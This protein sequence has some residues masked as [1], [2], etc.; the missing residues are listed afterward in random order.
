MARILL[1]LIF[2]A[3]MVSSGK[4]QDPHFSQ[5]FA[6]PLTLNPAF[7]GKIDGTVRAAVNYRNQWPSINKAFQTSTAS[8]DFGIL[9]NRISFTDIWGVGIAGFSDQS[10]N[11]AVK[12]NYASAS[13]AY[14]KG[15]DED[16][17]HQVGVGFQVTYANMIINTS[18]LKFED[19]LTSSGFTGVTGEVFNNST[20]KGNYMDLNAGLLYSGST[21]DKNNFYGGISMYHINRPK[22]AFTGANYLLQPR[23]T[24][25][26]GGYFPV[27]ESSYV[28]VSGLY[29]TQAGAN[30]T[31]VGGAFQHSIGT[32]TME[33]PVSFFAG[34][35]IRLKDAMIPY[36]GLEFNDFR[37]GV[38][39]D[40]NTSNLKSASQSRGGIELSLIYIHRPVDGRSIPCPKF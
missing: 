31:V 16:G 9:R 27:G 35:W 5:F 12:F 34:A 33:K 32:E 24:L 6:S 8:V 3:G 36:V 40:V 1:L 37:L 7:T 20:L 11:G 38:S 14:H 22:Q 18:Q 26:G 4:T 21:S 25:H 30:E 13:T 28:H 23:L 15:L 17:Y 10:A 29:S 2:V 19:Q 39:Y